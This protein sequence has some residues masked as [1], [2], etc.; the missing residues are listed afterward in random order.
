M[1]SSES[2]KKDSSLF[3][4]DLRQRVAKILYSKPKKVEEGPKFILSVEDALKSRLLELEAVDKNYMAPEVLFGYQCR[5][6]LI[7]R[8]LQDGIVDTFQFSR[9][10]AA[11]NPFGCKSEF[12]AACNEILGIMQSAHVKRPSE[13][14]L[15]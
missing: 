8:L 2:E 11:S 9:D 4:W 10:M 14:P 6:A 5:I 12:D 1:M 13:K 3:S 7:K 15:Q